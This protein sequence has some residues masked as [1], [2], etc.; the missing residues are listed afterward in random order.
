MRCFFIATLV[1]CSPV[2]RPLED[3]PQAVDG[4]LDAP[5]ADTP[6]SDVI[7]GAQG[8][9]WS[10]GR[11]GCS[12]ELGCGRAPTLTSASRQSGTVDN[13]DVSSGEG[14]V[15]L[16]GDETNVF[17]AFGD[18]HARYIRR[19]GTA[20]SIPRSWVSSPAVDATYV[21]WFDDTGALRRAARSGDG[22]DGM[23][24]ATGNFVLAKLGHAAGYLWWADSALHRISTTGGA[25][26]IVL[27]DVAAVSTIGDAIYVGRANEVGR[28]DVDC[29]YHAIATHPGLAHYFAL[30]GATLAWA[31]ED[32]IYTA[33]ITGGTA[34]KI[35][36]GYTSIFAF[37]PNEL[38]VD[39]TR[40]GYR[41]IPR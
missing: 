32:A 2:E 28:V 29:T 5:L 27:P 36:D 6:T 9:I 18:E 26:M 19:N 21:Y 7:I 8:I 39:F 41:S 23:T 16:V 13:G 4:E 11:L 14:S 33:P 3:A 17:Y 1:A 10:R 24:I 31:T 22:F 37:L 30:D 12:L 35:H 38:L 40:Y 25:A 20:L 34:A 15:G